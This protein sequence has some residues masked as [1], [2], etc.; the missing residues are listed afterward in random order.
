[1]LFDAVLEERLE[2]TEFKN[3]DIIERHDTFAIFNGAIWIGDDGKIRA[4]NYNS[5]KEKQLR[6]QLHEELEN[7]IHERVEDWEENV[8]VCEAENFLIRIDLMGN[9]EL[10]YISWS[11]PKSIKEKPDLMLF[12]GK[13]EFQGTMGGVTYT[14][15]NGQWIYQIDRVTMAESD[16]KQGTFLKLYNGTKEVAQYKAREIK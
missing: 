11:Y 9:N 1:V 7:T 4:I 14:F 8:L 3:S 2:A 10:R 12:N 6:N 16:E 5:G 13:E 15:R